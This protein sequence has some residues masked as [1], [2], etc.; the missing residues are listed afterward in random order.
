MIQLIIDCCILPLYA[1]LIC[2]IFRQMSVKTRQYK[3]R[4]TMRVFASVAKLEFKLEVTKH[5]MYVQT[6]HWDAF[7]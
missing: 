1:P 4:R 7:V 5:A 2:F 3:T 6:K